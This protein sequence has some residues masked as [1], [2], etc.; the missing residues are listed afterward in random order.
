MTIGI[1]G[2]VGGILGFFATRSLFGAFLGYFIGSTFDKFSTKN[3]NFSSSR[4]N[5]S[6]DANYYSQRLSQNDFATALLI[7]SAAVMKADGKILKS[8]LDY[9][10][11]FF[12]QQFSSHLSSKYISDFKDILKKD[13]VLSDV[14]STINGSMPIRQRSL[15]IQY[16]FGI[17]QA[18]GLVSDSEMKVIQ[19]ISS[20]FR[21]S[22]IEFEQIKSL[23]Y[24][25]VSSYY[26]VLG[27]DE[28]A[29]NDEVKKAY[30]KMA[31]KHHPDKFSQLG[32]EQQKAAKNK[33]Q[34]IQEAYEHIKKE[35]SIK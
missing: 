9:V 16:L 23:F 33:F 30:R 11:Q 32:E 28:S 15:L 29:S 27:I 18:D 14:C 25:D 5:Y 1:G 31:I 24:K 17:A 3:I 6:Y 26:K 35:R 2:L 12:K 8:E 21:I 34:K 4:S 19:R 22:S 10:K 13:F 7:L 20:Y